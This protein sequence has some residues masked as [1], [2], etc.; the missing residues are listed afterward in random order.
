VNER[1]TLCHGPVTGFLLGAKRN[2]SLL[3]FKAATEQVPLEEM[4]A[5]EKRAFFHVGMIPAVMGG[6]DRG[7][8]STSHK[9]KTQCPGRRTNRSNNTPT[10]SHNHR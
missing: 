3:A 9:Y 10:R 4:D 5:G 7:S 8:T 2:N 1:L 6:S